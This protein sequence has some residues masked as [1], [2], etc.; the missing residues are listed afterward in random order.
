MRG[1]SEKEIN[2]IITAGGV[3]QKARLYLRD[4]VSLLPEGTEY[5]LDLD[6][7]ESLLNSVNLFERNEFNRLVCLGQ[8]VEAGIISLYTELNIILSLRQALSERLVQKEN[9]TNL[10]TVINL[11]LL[12]CCPSDER[13][14][15][16]ASL[17]REKI[18][19][20]ML[21]KVSFIQL[22]P[23]F[24]SDGF[25]DLKLRMMK[26]SSMMETSLMA[27][28]DREYEQMKDYIIQETA[29]KK[30]IETL[31]KFPDIPE[32]EEIL[33]TYKNK[34]R[35]PV[36]ALVKETGRQALDSVIGKDNF[37]EMYCTGKGSCISHPVSFRM[38][39]KLKEYDRALNPDA[40][41][42]DTTLVNDYFDSL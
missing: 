28:L 31:E 33:E 4:R 41:E 2:D 26:D 9:L 37:I 17:V 25:L 11:I 15:T 12:E 20:T 40:V 13:D 38:I 24:D 6:Q 1:Y 27:G 10:E 5:I 22:D 7:Q 42:I 39:R 29:L 32:Y 19:S 16:D 18:L 36:L 30:F 21:E 35:K 8:R 3:R 34:L 14:R 23:V